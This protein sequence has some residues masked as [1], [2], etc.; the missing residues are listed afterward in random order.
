MRPTAASRAPTTGTGVALGPGREFSLI[1]AHVRAAAAQ[2][3]NPS[4]VL[5][6]GDDAALI[7]PDPAQLIALAVDTMVEGRHYWPHA[8]PQLLGHKLLCVNLSDLAAMGAEPVVCTLSLCLREDACTD[9]LSAFARGLGAATAAFG[10]TLVGG[11]TVRL[12]VGAPNV[13]TLQ[14]LG[15]VP[16]GLALRRDAMVPG[17]EIW[18]SGRLGDPADAVSSMTDNGKLNQP[19]PRL[20]LGYFLRGRAHAAI[21]LSDGLASELGHLLAASESRLGQALSLRLNLDALSACLGDR[22]TAHLREGRLSR[23]QA[24]R[25]AAEGG[26]EYELVFTAPPEQHD[27]LVQWGLEHALAM[28]PIGSAQVVGDAHPRGLDWW[29]QSVRCRPEDCPRAGFD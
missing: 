13:L 23:L 14:V 25:L 11:D 3:T 26:D 4:V 17:D 24:C 9:W 15:Q 16:P 20:D 29:F 8:D 19:T 28:T 18:V 22:L 2:S 5:G 1:D 6:I 12:P 21:D 7:A 27:A 10:C